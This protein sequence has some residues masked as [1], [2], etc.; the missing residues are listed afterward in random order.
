MAKI[1]CYFWA[2]I[3]TKEEDVVL[4]SDIYI[5]ECPKNA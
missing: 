3:L 1:L 2:M 5:K 4:L